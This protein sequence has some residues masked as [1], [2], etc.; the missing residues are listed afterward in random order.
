MSPDD[1]TALFT[2]A[3]GSYR[4][5]RWARPIV[6][7]VFG[8][9]EETLS[10]VKGACEAV[11]ALAGHKMAELDHEQ[12]ANLFVFFFRE[13]RE[14]LDV[15]DLGGMIP[16]LE[17]VVAR[18]EAADASSYRA[19]RFEAEGAIRAGWVFVRMDAANAAVPAE[20][21][22]LAQMVQV[23]LL[24]SEQAFAETSPLALAEGRAVLRPE[25]AQVIVAGYDPVMPAAATD[26]SHALRL[27]ARMS[28]A[29]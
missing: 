26:P 6:P 20:D 24:W 8:V 15:P 17:A 25:I 27:H 22:A 23:I 10:I 29:Q 14:L 2:R 4:F 3:D 16:D 7:V 19:F 1:V 9:E 11:V 12:G 21:L 28:V 18:L 13:W 5:A